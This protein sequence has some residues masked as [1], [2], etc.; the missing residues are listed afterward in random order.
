[1]TERELYKFRAEPIIKRL[2]EMGIDPPEM[3]DAK[4]QVETKCQECKGRGREER[5]TEDGE[6]TDLVHCPTCGGSGTIINNPL[7]DWSVKLIRMM[8]N[9][10]RSKG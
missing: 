6:E 8:D 9:G 10:N 3:P 1:M 2:R 5:V 4:G 7:L